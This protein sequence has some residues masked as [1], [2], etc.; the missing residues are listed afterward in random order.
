MK[1]VCNES[2]RVLDLILFM[3]TRCIYIGAYWVLL[4]SYYLC[5]G[6]CPY[7]CIFPIIH[8]SPLYFR[9]L[10]FIIIGVPIA[11]ARSGLWTERGDSFWSSHTSERSGNARLTHAQCA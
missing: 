10:M 9:V 2:L 4:T 1:F 11:H 3:F 7:S 5:V 6:V 8:A